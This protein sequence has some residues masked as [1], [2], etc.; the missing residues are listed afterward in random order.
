LAAATAVS[1]SLSLLFLAFSHSR[2]YNQMHGN[3]SSLYKN[4]IHIFD[5]ESQE[6]LFLFFL[7]AAKMYKSEKSAKEDQSRKHSTFECVIP[8]DDAR[9]S[10]SSTPD[11]KWEGNNNN[12][13]K[14]K[15]INGKKPCVSP[16]LIHSLFLFFF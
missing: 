13:Q 11:E 15:Y 9:V 1:L 3:G 2:V 4:P 6:Y 8:A 7:R 5:R 16:K 10:S 14:K 12:N